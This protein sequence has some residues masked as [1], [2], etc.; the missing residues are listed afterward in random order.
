[1]PAGLPVEAYPENLYGAVVYGKGPL[2]FAEMREQVGD[3]TFTQ[4]LQAYFQQ[5]RYGIAYPQDFL[6][7]AQEV[8]GQDMSALYRQWIAGQN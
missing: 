7:V 6:L 5:H 1:M 4:I 3:E 8:S 2:F